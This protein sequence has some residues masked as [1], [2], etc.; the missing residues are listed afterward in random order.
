MGL[1][2]TA[3]SEIKGLFSS[4]KVV[5][6]V[7]ILLAMTFPL[8]LTS[9]FGQVD[10]EKT[11][12]AKQAETLNFMTAIGPLAAA[13]VA[14]AGSAYIGP[15]ITNSWKDRERQMEK[16]QKELE[17]QIEL[18][19]KEL[20]LKNAFVVEI[21]QY[22]MSIIVAIMR[23][24]EFL[25]IIYGDKND[26]NEDKNDISNAQDKLR[27]LREERDNEYKKFLVRSHIIQS[28]IQAYFNE[29][30]RECSFHDKY[31]PCVCNSSSKCLLCEWNE[32]MDFVK[33]IHHLSDKHN[34]YQREK[35]LE[36][37]E[38]IEQKKIL[39]LLEIAKKKYYKIHLEELKEAPIGD[40]L[41]FKAM[42][43]NMKLEAWYEVK[44][45]IVD[46]KDE[47]IKTILMTEIPLFHPAMKASATDD[48]S[49]QNRTLYQTTSPTLQ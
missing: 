2:L 7:T 30:L 3:V 48:T 25:N 37:P 24:E 29:R 19:Q 13:S 31:L 36:N 18:N 12:T 42:L 1:I 8:G 14:V 49:K 43:S 9:V 26:I 16:E 20:E 22:V 39:A 46:K 17:K 38:Q 45:G 33:F 44:H 47:V 23:V 4:S 5:F 27:K 15:K 28:K 35:Y 6:T 40:K 32:M 11:T 41:E 21:S 34:R 10:N